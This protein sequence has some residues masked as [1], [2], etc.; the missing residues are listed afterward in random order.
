[1]FW[2]SLPLSFGISSRLPPVQ[3]S[4]GVHLVLFEWVEKS[5]SLSEHVCY[6]VVSLKQCGG[7]KKQGRLLKDFGRYNADTMSRRSK[8]GR[9]YGEVHKRMVHEG[10]IYPQLEGILMD[11]NVHWPPLTFHDIIVEFQCGFHP[12]SMEITSFITHWGYLTGI[13]IVNRK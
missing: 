11:M 5:L 10:V 8:R 7:V 12:N 4:P 9:W 3:R 13:H 1:M 2:R 6:G